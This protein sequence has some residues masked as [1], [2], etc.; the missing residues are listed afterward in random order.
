MVGVVHLDVGQALHLLLGQ[1]HLGTIV[2]NMELKT[3][4]QSD[5]QNFRVTG[6]DHEISS[7]KVLKCYA[8]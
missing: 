6:I 8:K 2:D 5:G 3:Q 7:L 4:E 1:A